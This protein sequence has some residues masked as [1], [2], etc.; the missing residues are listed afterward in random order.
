[1]SDD[2]KSARLIALAEAVERHLKAEGHEVT[3]TTNAGLTAF[4]IAGAGGSFYCRIQS[5]GT[6]SWEMALPGGQ[7]LTGMGGEAALLAMVGKAVSQAE[8]RNAA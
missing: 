4:E 1:M 6:E 5:L 8:R 3:V 7:T 2:L